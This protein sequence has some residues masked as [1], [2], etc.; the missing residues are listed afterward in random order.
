MKKLTRQKP[1]MLKALYTWL[2]ENEYTPLIGVVSDYPKNIFPSFIKKEGLIVLNISESALNNLSIGKE[3][4]SIEATINNDIAYLEFLS[5]SVAFIKA[6]EDE[7]IYFEFDVCDYENYIKNY[8]V[9]DK[10]PFKL[11]IVK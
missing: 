9:T 3:V 2:L 7:D 1:H 4:M 5:E 11:E 6:E 8:K 10:Q